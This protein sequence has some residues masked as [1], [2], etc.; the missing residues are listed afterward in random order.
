MDRLGLV[1]T[2]GSRGWRGYAGPV[3]LLLAATVTIWLLRGEFRHHASPPAATIVARAR[4]GSHH[5]G[6]D[7]LRRA[8]RRHA[9][10][11]RRAD[12]RPGRAAARTEHADLADSPLHRRAAP[13]PMRPTLAALVL[14]ASAWL[15]G[16]RRGGAAR[17]RARLARREPCHRAGPRRARRPPPVADR[18]DHQADDGHR[19]PPAPEPLRGGLRRSARRGRRPGVD[20]PPA[21]PADHRRRPP[22]RRP[23]PVG[24][25]RRRR[26]RSRDRAELRRLRHR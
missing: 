24:Q 6:P 14:A 12:A 13:A 16:Y 1:T 3:L 11:D 2:A 7:A 10:G 20:L 9:D 17:R 4:P 26:A 5:A 15:A 21:R 23:D 22:E 19:R 8:R 18:L 25:R